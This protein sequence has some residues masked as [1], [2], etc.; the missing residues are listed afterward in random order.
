[1]AVELNLWDRRSFHR[2]MPKEDFH[3]FGMGS[4]SVAVEYYSQS[5]NALIDSL[6]DTRVSCGKCITNRSLV[7]KVCHMAS[8]SQAVHW[9]PKCVMWQVHH[10]PFTGVQSVS[11]G[12]CIT[13]RSLLS[14]VCH[15]ASAS[16]A[17]HWCPKC[18]T[19]Q[20]HYKPFTG[21]KS[22]SCGKCITSRSLVSKVCHVASASQA[23]P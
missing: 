19:W 17:V 7:S 6:Y 20:V 9:Y 4:P 1:M 8:A 21:V 2:A 22:V 5:T 11:C 16:Q 15:V 3:N 23:V 10:K 18:V 14:K 12:K 13:S